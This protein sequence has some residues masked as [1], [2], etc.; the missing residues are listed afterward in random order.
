M[1]SSEALAEIVNAFGG[2]NQIDPVHKNRRA[3]RVQH[4]GRTMIFRT[5]EAIAESAVSI[6]MR[7]ISA[8]GCSFVCKSKLAFGSTF[9]IQ[10]SRN[11]QPPTG[12]LCTV[13]H[14]RSITGGS[15]KIGAEF[16]CTLEKAA[17]KATNSSEM[18]RIRNSILT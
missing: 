18:D 13:V 5:G 11:G 16:T 8:R 10:F 3:A 1:L 4:N 15:F 17:S 7:D 6:Q 12:M 14:C 2:G 9:V